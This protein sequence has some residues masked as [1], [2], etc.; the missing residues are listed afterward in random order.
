MKINLHFLLILPMLA[1]LATNAAFWE[2]IYGP[3]IDQEPGGVKVYTY[4]LFGGFTLAIILWGRYMQS[5]ERWWLWVTLAAI[6]GLMLESYADTGSWLVYPH[7][8]SKLFML[9]IMFGTYAFYRRYGLPSMGQL[10]GALTFVLLANLVVF[11]RDSLSLSA[12]AENERGFQSSSAY[13][14]VPVALYC[15]NRYLTHGGVVVLFGFFFCLPLIIFLQHRSVWIATVIAIPIDL[16][17]MRRSPS[18]RFSFPQLLALVVLPGI[19][20]SLGVTAVV[21]NEYGGHGQR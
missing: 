5:L 6:G 21:L 16:W 18:A 3:Q 9:L 4:A 8:F 2:F 12:F 1:I 13:L 17:L 15:L 11:H 10:M 7:V 14:L 20:G 19:L